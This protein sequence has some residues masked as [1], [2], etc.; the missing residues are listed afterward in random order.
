MSTV[1]NP[2]YLKIYNT[3]IMCIFFQTNVFNIGVLSRD[4]QAE[5]LLIRFN[6][7]F[8][9]F[10]FCNVKLTCERSLKGQL[11]DWRLGGFSFF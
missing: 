8:S 4:I 1:T 3:Y 5:I 2:P 9:L 10:V 6:V 7:R 11:K